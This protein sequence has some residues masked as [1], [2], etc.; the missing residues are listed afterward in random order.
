[1][2]IG[3]IH[4]GPVVVALVEKLVKESLFEGYRFVTLSDLA[5]GS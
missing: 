1:M 4:P 3:I 5:S 2:G